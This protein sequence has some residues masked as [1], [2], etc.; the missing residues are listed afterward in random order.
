[1]ICKEIGYACA[2][3]WYSGYHWNIQ[4]NFNVILD[5]VICEDL[6]KP[7]TACSHSTIH[8]CEHEQDVFVECSSVTSKL[9]LTKI[10]I[11]H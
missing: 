3:A 2:R 5:E 6:T 9:N 8:N 11:D 1:M 10:H 4:S 7:F